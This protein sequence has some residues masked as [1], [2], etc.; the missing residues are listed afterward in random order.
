MNSTFDVSVIIA[1]YNGAGKLPYLLESLASQTLR[2]FELIVVI[3]GSTDNS[4]EV[5]ESYRSRLMHLK[6]IVQKNAGRSKVRNRGVHEATGS[7]LIFY[8]DDMV[9]PPD[10]VARHVSFHQNNR[11]PLLLCGNQKEFISAASTDIQRYKAFISNKWL[12]RY[13]DA[14]ASITFENLFFSAANSS[15]KREAFERLHGFD[16]RLTDAEDYDLAYRALEQGIAI[17]FDKLNVCV[18]RDF[19]TCRS[20]IKR[21]RSYSI[22]NQKLIQL[23]PQRKTVTNVTSSSVKRLVYKV[24]AN[25]CIPAWIDRQLFAWLPQSWRFKIYDLTIQALAIE[26]PEVN[27]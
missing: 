14:F 10:S 12:A 19:I 1:T 20:Y 26:Y 22:A 6:V 16:E 9:L 21:L 25:R 2:E 7:I 5:I 4:K 8:D 13:N 24:L 11:M 17:F 3:D 15:A 23:N 27:V 18:H